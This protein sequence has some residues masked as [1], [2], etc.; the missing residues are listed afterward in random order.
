[1]A[2]RAL[3]IDDDPHVRRSFSRVLGTIG[4]EAQGA[5]TI[6]TGLDALQQ[7]GG[8]FA[9]VLLDH[10]LPDGNG[11]DA[12]PRLLAIDRDLP[13]IMVTGFG[14]GELAA[15]ALKLG[16]VDFIEK[17]VD[18]QRLRQICQAAVSR[19][20]LNRDVR[21]EEPDDAPEMVVRSPRMIELLELID[22]LADLDVNVLI[23]GETGVGK[24]LV[25]RRLHERSSRRSHPFVA[26]NCAA[27]PAELLESE[28]FGHERGAFTSAD[29][30]HIGKFQQAG[31]GTIFL[32]ELGEMPAG[33]QA[34]LLRVIQDRRIQP[35]GSDKIV[36]VEARIVSATN[37]SLLD[38]VEN[39]T[40][41][42]DLYYRLCQFSVDVPPLRERREEIPELAQHVLQQVRQTGLEVAGLANGT[43]E[44][45]QQYHWPGN[46]R[47]L[48]N[49]I[50]RAAILAN[51]EQIELRHFPAE[52]LRDADLD[53][54]FSPPE[55]AVANE[56]LIPM[57]QT[58]D[59]ILSLE[60]VERMVI[61][62]A[63]TV[64]DGNMSEAAKRLG[65]GR[66][67]L[68]RKVT[69]ADA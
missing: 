22:R 44:F 10:S 58:P 3:I 63:L 16:A 62:A 1:M 48:E 15:R 20:Q 65:I 66:A 30:R 52:V 50:R 37:R 51:G 12:L 21:A 60:H 26:I 38:M 49:V 8:A 53:V 33:L 55:P 32:D 56:A 19:R 6:E 45:M 23:Y 24:E 61:D 27:I 4:I 14:S 64:C 35:L 5:E 59:D 42:E 25:A 17:P 18:V 41:R 34:K 28:L 7:A 36:R 43:L 69:P 40:F 9:L 11:I 47:Q 29:S 13:V 67:T 46:I 39:G 68:Y 2:E 31:R 57:F 54:D